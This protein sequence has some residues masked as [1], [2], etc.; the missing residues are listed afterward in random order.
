MLSVFLALGSKG[1]EQPNTRCLLK[2]TKF[3]KW[4]SIHL[5]TYRLQ[6]RVDVRNY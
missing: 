3:F 5:S 6:K 1:M 2:A 4:V